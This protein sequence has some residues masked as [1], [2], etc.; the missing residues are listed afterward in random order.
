MKNTT[1]KLGNCLRELRIAADYTQD[2]VAAALGVVRQTYSHYETGNREPNCEILFKLASLYHISPNDLFHLCFD[3]DDS[4]F[5][6]PTPAPT[7]HELSGFLKFYS[8]GAHAQVFKHLSSGEKEILYLFKQLDDIE[9]LE[10]I[11]IARIKYMKKNK[12]GSF[13]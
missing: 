1:S 3:L 7:R 2:D 6:A 4:Y 9:Q 12:E 10:L 8:E 11:E 5:D 13:K